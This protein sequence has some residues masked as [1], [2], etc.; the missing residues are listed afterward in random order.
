[1]S[2]NASTCVR[3]ERFKLVVFGASVGKTREFVLA[4][5]RENGVAGLEGLAKI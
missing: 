1:M 4:I 5:Q 3:L 2:Q